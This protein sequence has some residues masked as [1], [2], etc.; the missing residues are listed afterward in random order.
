MAVGVGSFLGG[1]SVSVAWFVILGLP[2][3]GNPAGASG[4]VVPGAGVTPPGIQIRWQTPYPELRAELLT[5]TGEVAAS[6][7]AQE[8]S[9]QPIQP[10]VYRIRISDRAGRWHMLE[11]EIRVDPG[12]VITVAPTAD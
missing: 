1:A 8:P 4:L 10:G 12:Q 7:S 3:F 11:R 6:S 5:P 9:A 2:S